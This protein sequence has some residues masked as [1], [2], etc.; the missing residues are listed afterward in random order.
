M[1]FNNI[2]G[3][4][5]YFRDAFM[6]KY[7]KSFYALEVKVT[8]HCFLSLKVKTYT[9][10]QNVYGKTKSPRYLFD[11]KSG[12]FRKRLN[13][14]TVDESKLYVEKALNSKKKNTTPFMRIFLK[15]YNP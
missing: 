12:R 2:G 1:A 11:D 5:Y 14:D 7:P 6:Q 4:L 10:L 3:N 8:Y 15:K 13:N 9:C